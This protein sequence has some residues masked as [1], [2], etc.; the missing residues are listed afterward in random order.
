M[1]ISATGRSEHRQAGFTLV[2]I[3]V[4]LVVLG[5]LATS[6]VLTLPDP[7]EAAQR[8]SVLSWQRQLEEAALRAE[9]EARPWA[10]E[11]TA[12][13]SRLLSQ[14]DGRWRSSGEAA[15]PLA[16]GLRLGA[17]EIDGQPR[18]IHSRIVFAGA[19][20]LFALELSAAHRR[21]RITGLPNG[22]IVQEEL[23]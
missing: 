23:P 6:V 10:W 22:R 21:W 14:R 13:G 18:P 5:V 12:E 1:P 15:Q 2:E 17:L 9:A 3:L 8:S 16:E 11:I 7:K 4:A 20:P 19:A